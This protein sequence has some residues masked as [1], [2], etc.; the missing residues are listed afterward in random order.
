[1]ARMKG[2]DCTMNSTL[3]NTPR[4]QDNREGKEMV[5][6]DIIRRLAPTSPPTKTRTQHVHF[7]LCKA[8]NLHVMCNTEIYTQCAGVCVVVG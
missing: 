4:Q 5:A 3:L 8:A 7:S 2:L 1:M 6:Y